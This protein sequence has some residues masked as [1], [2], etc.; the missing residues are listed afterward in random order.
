MSNTL[1]KK[2]FYKNNVLAP[3]P[4]SAPM[5]KGTLTSNLMLL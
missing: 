1:N 4:K 5:A 2:Y 3:G